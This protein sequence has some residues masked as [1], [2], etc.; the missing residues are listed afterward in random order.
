MNIINYTV[1]YTP[2]L[3]K[4]AA[5]ELATF[6]GSQGTRRAYLAKTP[7]L[8]YNGRNEHGEWRP[9]PGHT[10]P[11]LYDTHHRDELHPHVQVDQP[12]PVLHVSTVDGLGRFRLIVTVCLRVTRVQ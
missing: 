2:L 1:N 12:L 11:A 9:S 8:A 7:K 4:E 3:K 10:G 6:Q 5:D